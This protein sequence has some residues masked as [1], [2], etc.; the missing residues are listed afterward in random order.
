MDS[1]AWAFCRELVLLGGSNCI[2][3]IVR[4]GFETPNCVL[5]REASS[6]VAFL[7][8]PRPEVLRHSKTG[9]TSWTWTYMY[10]C[11][12]MCCH[13]TAKSVSRQH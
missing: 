13:D 6:N 3:T 5:C 9:H 11:M 1:S 8:R 10:I 4:E 2:E 7:E 12:H